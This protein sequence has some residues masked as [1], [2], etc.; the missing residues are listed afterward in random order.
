MR[1]TFPPASRSC[2]RRGKAP[3][4]VPLLGSALNGSRLRL[5]IPNSRGGE[6]SSQV[7]PS[8]PALL[9][10]R[11]KGEQKS[12]SPLS[13]SVGEG[14]GVRAT[15]LPSRVTPFPPREGGRGVRSRR[16]GLFLLALWL[17]LPARAQEEGFRWSPRQASTIAPR[18]DALF[19]TISGIAALIAL[20][21]CFLIIYFCVKYRRGSKADRSNP[22]NRNIILETAWIGIPVLL[23]LSIFVWAARVY[24]DIYQAP[25]GA[26]DIYVVGKQWMW[27]LQH[28]EGQR[29]INELHVPIG[30]PVRLIL[31]SQDVIHSFFVPDFRI[32]QDVL[33]GRTTTTWFEATQPGRYRIF[34]AQYCGMNHSRMRGWV[35]AMPQADYE[36]WLSQGST[37]PSM[38]AEGA[39]LYQQLGCSGCHGASN[40]VRAPSLDGIYGKPVPL[41]NR[42]IVIADD[43]YIHDSILLPKAQVVAGYKPVMPSFKGLI[44]EEQ[45]LELTAFIKSLGEKQ[46]REEPRAPQ[47]GGGSGR[48][49]E[50][51]QSV[52]ERARET[53]RAQQ[54]GGSL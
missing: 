13:R 10:P 40:T 24:V 33:P 38:A 54:G 4:P 50:Q 30:R 46:G 51:R 49:E 20:S 44:T 19:Y 53:Q 22:P 6:S 21:V 11:E 39:R 41:S 32:K 43:R 45:V 14:A 34:C 35:Y 23:A 52:K 15:T 47:G 17:A 31:S 12:G 5:A 3:T 9:P 27:K 28:P 18:V 36:R 48:V 16:V 1:T 29:E 37:G 42:Q 8:S 26:I 25:P 7:P 2:V